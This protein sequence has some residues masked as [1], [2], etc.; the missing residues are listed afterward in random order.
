MT[1]GSAGMKLQLTFPIRVQESIEL[2]KCDELWAYEAELHSTDLILGYPFLTGFGLLVDSVN[3]CL[4]LSSCV[5][6]QN[7][8]PKVPSDKR[9]IEK[10]SRG[11]VHSEAVCHRQLSSVSH[12]DQCSG[13]HCPSSG[14]GSMQFP[15]DQAHDALA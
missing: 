9:K 3:C 4:S 7:M 2:V 6:K 5:L 13:V 10:F 1:G 12:Q 8:G 15:N 11:A 14:A